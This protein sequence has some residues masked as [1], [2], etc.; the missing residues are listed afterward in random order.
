M[1]RSWGKRL[2][3]PAGADGTR[4]SRRPRS[5]PRSDGV[6]APRL[7]ARQF[8]PWLYQQLPR[9][10]RREAP[11]SVPFGS[12]KSAHH[13]HTSPC[14]SYRPSLFDAYEP[15]LVVRSRYGPLSVFPFGKL[16]S[17]FASFEDR[18]FVGFT[19]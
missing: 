16:P 8:A 13:C 5:R 7:V 4:A 6:S 12:Y 18:S 17:K 11:T 2:Y 19:K 1:W 9:H 10:T 3:L 14:M 15:T